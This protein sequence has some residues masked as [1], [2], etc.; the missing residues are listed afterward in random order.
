M[1]ACDMVENNLCECFNSWILEA[2]YNPIVELLDDIRLKVMERLH[3]KRDFMLK[4]DCLIYPQI[5]RKLNFSIEATKFCK[6]TWTGADEC[7]A[8]DIDGGQWVVNMVQKTCS[9]RR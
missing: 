5:I 2:W 9:C 6:S 7:E 4:R 1:T 8:R 3:M